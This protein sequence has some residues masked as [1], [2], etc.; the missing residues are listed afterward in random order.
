M[1]WSPEVMRLCAGGACTGKAVAKSVVF[2]RQFFFYG[3]LCI[4]FTTF[5][6]SAAERRA[7]TAK[8]A[9]LC[10]KSMQR[11]YSVK[12]CQ[13]SRKT[14]TCTVNIGGGGFVLAPRISARA[15][16]RTSCGACISA[17]VAVRVPAHKLRCAYQRASCGACIS[18]HVAAPPSPKIH[19]SRD[20]MPGRAG[21]NFVDVGTARRRARTCRAC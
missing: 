21:F 5:R 19:G 12:T 16:K 11:I 2:Q 17:Q 10:G 9:I 4:F 20:T 13:R 15:Y 6:G 14:F 1:K 3:L 18:A 7:H 8:C